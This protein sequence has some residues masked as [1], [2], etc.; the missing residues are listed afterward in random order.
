MDPPG[1]R[2]LFV[3]AGLELYLALLSDVFLFFGF[4]DMPGTQPLSGALQQIW[5]FSFFDPGPGVS[6]GPGEAP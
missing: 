3:A 6:G 5:D 4:L 1:V 2:I